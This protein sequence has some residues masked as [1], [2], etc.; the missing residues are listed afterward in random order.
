MPIFFLYQT[1]CPLMVVV[2]LVVNFDCKVQGHGRIFTNHNAL[3]MERIVQRK[4]VISPSN[5][6]NKFLKSFSSLLSF[7]GT[8]PFES[9]SWLIFAFD[10]ISL[11]HC[12]KFLSA[13]AAVSESPVHTYSYLVRE[14]FLSRWAAYDCW[15]RKNVSKA[16]D[17]WLSQKKINYVEFFWT[18]ETFPF[19]IVMANQMTRG[20]IEFPK[21]TK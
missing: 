18:W 16:T 20:S 2:L 4:K 17:Y 19:E 10:A 9:S 1:I 8:L 12:T 15:R 5:K 13:V 14:I 21:L 11:E 6:S 7:L 3:W